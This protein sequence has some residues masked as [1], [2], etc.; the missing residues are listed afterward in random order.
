MLSNDKEGIFLG[1]IKV[2]INKQE[3]PR[4]TLCPKNNNII[5]YIAELVRIKHT[6]L[7]YK[8]INILFQCYYWNFKNQ[9]Y[10]LHDVHGMNNE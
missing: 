6:V 9:L 4:V 3:S 10:H 7:Q 8:I 1:N 2:C 5:I